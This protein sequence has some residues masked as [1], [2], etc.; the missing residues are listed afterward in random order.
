MEWLF[1]NVLLSTLDALKCSLWGN[2]SGFCTCLSLSQEVRSFSLS[3]QCIISWIAEAHWNI[4]ILWVIYILFLEIG[5]GQ[6]EREKENM[7]FCC[8]LEFTRSVVFSREMWRRRVGSSGDI[9]TVE[10]MS[11]KKC[12]H[13]HMLSE[14]LRFWFIGLINKCQLMHC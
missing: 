5:G 7:K 2:S 10:F 1:W 14:N 12:S 9:S 3:A 8:V 13:I 11:F 6:M 4:S